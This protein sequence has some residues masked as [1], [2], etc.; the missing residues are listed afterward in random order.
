MATSK[1]STEQQVESIWALGGLTPLQLIKN[2]WKEIDQDNV[3]GR[4]SELAYNYLLAI[5]PFLLFLLA[6]FGL[7]ASRGTVL[8]TNLLF[9]FSEVL[10][11]AAFEL[12][13]KTIDEV[14]KN[15]T[16]GKVT[17]GIALA[18]WAASG[19]MTAMMSALNGAYGVRESRSWL[20][21]HAIAVGI[22]DRDFDPRHL[23]LSF[24]AGWRPHCQLCRSET[25]SRLGRCYWLEDTAMAG[26]L[27]LYRVGFLP[28]LLLRSER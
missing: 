26:S 28:D 4:G 8:R 14:T 19:G 25:P 27:F 10:P 21:V 16:G 2:V 23:R 22:D 17:L 6:V 11:P 20:K 9:Y 1:L 18:L 15:S 13:S 24:S 3:T 5:F 12:L 7:F